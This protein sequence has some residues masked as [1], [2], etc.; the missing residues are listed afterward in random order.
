MQQRNSLR[1]PVLA[2][3]L[4]ALAF[5]GNAW[6]AFTIS[7]ASWSNS[8]HTLTVSGSGAASRAT[9]TVKY[10]G[11]LVVIGTTTASRRG[12]WTFTKS[13][14]SP[15]P[16]KVRAESGSSSATR[17]VSNAPAN[18]SN[19]GGGGGGGGGGASKSINSTS[20][21]NSTVPTTAV[22][23]QTPTNQSEY[24]V[25]AVNDLG[26]HCGDLDTR[27]LSIL[28]PFN[29]INAQVVQTGS[30]PQLLD[31]SSVE[32]VYS[33]ASSANDP[34][35]LDP[36][37]QPNPPRSFTGYTFTG[38]FK[39]NFWDTARKAYDPF[40]PTGLLALFYPAALNIIDV[41]LAVPD[42][43]LLYLAGKDGYP[44]GTVLL[45]QQGMPSVT[46]T[47]YACTP[48]NLGSTGCNPPNQPR[49]ITDAAYTANNPQ[50]MA[51]YTGTLPFFS[52]NFGSS[53]G[54]TATVNW[55]TAEGVPLAEIDDSG[56]INPYPLM[57]VQARDKSSHSVLSSLDTVTPI[58]GEANCKNCHAAPVDGGNGLATTAAG[59]GTMIRT[60]IDDP[61]YGSVPLAVSVEWATDINILTL[62][63]EDHG[64]GSGDPNAYSPALSPVNGNNTDSN[65][66]A[67]NP[68]VCQTCHYTPALDLLQVGPGNS[69]LPGLAGQTNNQS[70]S[71]VVHN[72]HGSQTFPAG[73][74]TAVADDPVF[75]IMPVRTSSSRNAT[76]TANSNLGN[77]YPDCVG[78]STT[79]CTL[80]HACYN[81]HPG[82]RTKCLRGAMA[83]GGV[84]CQDCHGQMQQVGNDFSKN[85]PGGSFSLANDYYQLTN[86]AKPAPS[87]PR[88]P[89]AN[90]PGCGSCHTGDALDNCII[91]PSKCGAVSSSNLVKAWSVDA[92]DTIRLLQAYLASGNCTSL[93]DCA[94]IQP[95]PIVP[96]NP[97]FAENTVSGTPGNGQSGSDNPK[98][99]RVS[100]G[101]VPLTVNGSNA[102][103]SGHG[104]VFCEAC[105]GSTH[106][107]W[108]VDPQPANGLYPFAAGT[109][110]ANDN[111]TAGQLQGHTG[112]I[113]ECSTCHGTA[114]DNQITL[115]GPHGM[116]PVGNVRFVNG[117]HEDMADGSGRQ[118]C[119]ACHGAQ[120]QGTVLSVAKVDR[121]VSGHTI[122][123]GT[124][125]SCGICHGNPFTG[126]GGD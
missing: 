21:N 43:E 37:L 91:N 18:C 22:P 33:A 46:L 9:V 126:G 81:C 23:E 14:P 72:F 7:S 75:P 62:H 16:C 61:K 112:V 59:L 105:H 79:E 52:A 47:P 54:Y 34:A 39:S 40:Y 77:D 15:V 25:V 51:L 17:S 27:V 28:P 93:T 32:V 114:M 44:Q 49:S 87:T 13:N 2:G 108:P 45:D 3:S 53:F 41:G 123:R 102:G 92:T 80:N 116:H 12:S 94:T 106:A 58:S 125:V 65:G 107:E 98:L 64:P 57:R 67:T 86:G 36:A 1:W 84:V 89:W 38:V 121:Q 113:I 117:G 60:S 69:V 110:A 55:F 19:N 29:V 30:H 82:A 109:F 24:R 8:S 4:L 66:I 70:M 20:A 10:T 73:F 26:M 48:S 119:A 100:N 85:K 124:Q 111:V 56:R 50:R 97:R 118:K 11:D 63:D 120:G 90:E 115:D 5:A 83:S 71:R 6:A 31:D 103:E 96:S 122:T 101:G 78:Q 35:V 99:Y 88:V 68:V 74:G 95:A 76:V 42:N 104:G